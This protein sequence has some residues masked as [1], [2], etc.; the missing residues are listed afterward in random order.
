VAP[1]IKLDTRVVEVGWKAAERDGQWFSEW[2]TADYAAGFHQL[3]AYPGN[4]G[5]TVLAGHNNVRGEVFRYLVNLKRGDEIF[6]YAEDREYVYVVTDNFIVQEFGASEEQ[7]RKNAQWIA[8]T[9]D[10]R[11]TLV[12]CWPYWAY[13][14]RVIVIAR[15]VDRS[16]KPV[17]RPRPVE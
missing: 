9:E 6:L 17:G 14:H 11:L 15:P 8:P 1:S 2:Q 7:R 10:E 5:N 4:P 3:S 12:T 16:Q 13:T